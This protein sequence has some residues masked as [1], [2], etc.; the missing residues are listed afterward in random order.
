MTAL[1][2]PRI[3]AQEPTDAEVLE[4]VRVGLDLVHHAHHRDEDKLRAVIGTVDAQEAADLLP[5]LAGLAATLMLGASGKPALVCASIGATL[6]EAERTY[7]G[8]Q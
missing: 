8:R 3:G 2:P 4:L 1:P 7:G 6:H 5:F